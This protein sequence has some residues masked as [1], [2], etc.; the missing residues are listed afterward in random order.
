[1][2]V[3]TYF[4]LYFGFLVEKIFG[5]FWAVLGHFWV[6]LG[7]FE[8]FS[9]LVQFTHYSSRMVVITYFYLPF[10]FPTEKFWVVFGQF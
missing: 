6:V 1:M 3:I 2:V 9:E 7:Y 8:D 5:P 10:E 4:F